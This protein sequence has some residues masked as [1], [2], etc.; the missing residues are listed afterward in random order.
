MYIYLYYIYTSVALLS[1]W[2][3]RCNRGRWGRK[4]EWRK[5]KRRKIEDFFF[6]LSP[7]F[8]LSSWSSFLVWSTG[9]ELKLDYVGTSDRSVDVADRIL[10]RW[11][12]FHIEL[13]CVCMWSFF[14]L[15]LFSAIDRRAYHFCPSS[16]F[17][18]RNIYS[19]IDFLFIRLG[20]SHASARFAVVIWYCCIGHSTTSRTVS[21]LLKSNRFR[22]NFSWKTLDA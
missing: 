12:S 8:S 20:T 21:F 6:S 19:P 22:W 11:R 13:T 15:F 14:P 7:F 3:D 17:R 10:G 2:S 16:S 9:M 5:E 4:K 1:I 18:R